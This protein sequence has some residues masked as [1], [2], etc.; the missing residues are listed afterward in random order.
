MWKTLV[1]EIGLNRWKEFDI[2]WTFSPVTHLTKNLVTWLLYS[3]D[4]PASWYELQFKAC[5]NCAL[6]EQII[7]IIFYF[8]MC[9]W[10]VTGFL[11]TSSGWYP[12]P[13]TL[14]ELCADSSDD[15]TLCNLR[16]LHNLPTSLVALHLELELFFE[17]SRVAVLAL[18]IIVRFQFY[19]E[20]CLNW[21]LA[22]IRS[23]LRDLWGYAVLFSLTLQCPFKSA[24][25]YYPLHLTS[26]IRNY[27]LDYLLSTYHRFCQ[28]V[29]EAFWLS[30]HVKI[31]E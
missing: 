6:T 18:F 28:C 20:Q 16:V 21:C 4:L 30:Q 8:I 24:F 27:L 12:L 10:S 3:G 14:S 26:H 1:I 7:S 5:Q 2:I 29:C 31:P 22:T 13:S 15:N 11:R 25:V 23:T 17:V 19:H 9:H